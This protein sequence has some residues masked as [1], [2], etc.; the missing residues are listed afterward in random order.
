MVKA[1]KRKETKTYRRV[2]KSLEDRELEDW[3]L[4]VAGQEETK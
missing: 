4:G 1:R 3:M 2:R